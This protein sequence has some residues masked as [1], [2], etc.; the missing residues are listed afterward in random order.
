MEDKKDKYTSSDAPPLDFSF[1][2]IKNLEGLIN[3]IQKL[4]SP[5]LGKGQGL[6]QSMNKVGR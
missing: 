3:L 4:R 5:N 1:K 2:N 6:T